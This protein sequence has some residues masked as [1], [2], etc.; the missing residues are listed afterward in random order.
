MTH[1]N[2]LNLS[3]LDNWTIKLDNQTM[4][5]TIK[6]SNLQLRFGTKSG[7]EVS[8]IGNANDENNFPHMFLLTIAQV[9]KLSKAF[10]NNS[11]ANIKLSKTQLHKIKQSGGFL[12]RI[13]GPSLKTGLPLIGNVFKP[14][15]KIVLIPLQL[16]AAASAR[17]VTIHNKM[18]GHCKC[19]DIIY[20][21][22]KYFDIIKICK[23]L[24]E[25]GVLIKDVSQ[26]IEAKE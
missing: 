1:Y 3:K 11:S 6:L 9:W 8:I 21:I 7:T 14:L 13:L 15:A 4:N 17:D 26:T 20:G 2:T 16:T 24:E 10:A 23:P 22:K 25:S 5:Q 12:G 19:L 18:F